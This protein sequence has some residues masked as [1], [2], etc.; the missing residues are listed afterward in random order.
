MIVL[1]NFFLF[2]QLLYSL[3]V[4]D[5]DNNKID[6]RE[7]SDSSL[8]LFYQSPTC[9]QCWVELSAAITELEV[10][11]KIYIIIKSKDNFFLK[12]DFK[13][14]VSEYLK[15]DNCFYDTFKKRDKSDS[16]SNSVFQDYK[17][18]NTPSILIIKGSKEIFIPYGKLFYK[19]FT[20][21]T[22]K[23]ELINILKD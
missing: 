11:Q 21:K 12:V 16:V 8:I 18:L 19:G 14:T 13:N 10:K 5:L 3:N 23:K 1:Y 15:F 9:H 20:S 7:L 6:L 2:I 22:I 17:V 4:Y